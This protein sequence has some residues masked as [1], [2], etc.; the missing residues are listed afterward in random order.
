MQTPQPLHAH[1]RARTQGPC[2]GS[3]DWTG[4]T[5]E[6]PVFLDVY[7]LGLSLSYLFFYMNGVPQILRHIFFIYFY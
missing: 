2:T 4:C 6:G 3:T 5:R 1:H 7:I